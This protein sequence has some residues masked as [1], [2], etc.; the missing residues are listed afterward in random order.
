MAFKR[1]VSLVSILLFAVVFCT[2]VLP[3]YAMN[4]R[5]PYPWGKREKVE[6]KRVFDALEIRIDFNKMRAPVYVSNLDCHEYSR[7]YNLKSSRGY[8][9]VRPRRLSER[10]SS[11]VT[12]YVISVFEKYP[13]DVYFA[14]NGYGLFA[15]LVGEFYIGDVSLSQHL[16]EKGF[17]TR[18]END[19]NSDNDSYNSKQNF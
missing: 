14:P 6:V 17:C 19:Q 8:T 15:N 2:T 1:R 5:Y 10:V 16:I 12:D 9:Y 11:R 7:T 13:N 4:E 18:V 3:P